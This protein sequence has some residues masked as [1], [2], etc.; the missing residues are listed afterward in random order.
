MN[1]ESNE[2][3][4]LDREHSQVADIVFAFDNRD[5]L[6]L[7][8]KRYKYLCSAS[9]DKAEKIEERMTQLKNQQFD[10]L[11]VPNYY[12]CTFKDGQGQ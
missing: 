11:V 3:T 1:L 5:M 10:D 7:L 4:Q 12:F 2:L 6:K 9:F 8:K